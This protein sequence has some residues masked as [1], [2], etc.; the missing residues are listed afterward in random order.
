MSSRF[1]RLFSG[2]AIAGVLALSTTA[3]IR[4]ESAKPA[5][6]G[7]GIV[8]VKSA[9]SVAE[10]VSRLKQD[11]ASKGIMFFSAVDQSKLAADAGISSCLAT[12]RLAR[13]S[14]HPTPTPVSTGPCGCW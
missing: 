6:I 1:V 7:D 5:L 11:I 14:S 13:N 10:T 3:A 4:A 9:Y 12:R 8:K 2:A